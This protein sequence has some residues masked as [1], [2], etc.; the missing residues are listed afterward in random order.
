MKTIPLYTYTVDQIMD[1]ISREKWSENCANA[2]G[3]NSNLSFD[4]YIDMVKETKT[5]LI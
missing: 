3:L 4:Y 5:I 1:K 2:R